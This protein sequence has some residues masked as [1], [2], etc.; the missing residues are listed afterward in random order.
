[1]GNKNPS[2]RVVN[3]PAQFFSLVEKERDEV[4]CFTTCEIGSWPITSAGNH[5]TPQ[6]LSHKNPQTLSSSR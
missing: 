2:S 3:I 1:M 4:G 5:K 6:R